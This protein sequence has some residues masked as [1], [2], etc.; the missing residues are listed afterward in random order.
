MERFG[1]T[2]SA[3]AFGAAITPFVTSL[4]AIALGF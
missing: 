3:S 1:M 2:S 4:I